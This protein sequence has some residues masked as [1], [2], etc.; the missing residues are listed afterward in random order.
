MTESPT[1]AVA[2]GL[3]DGQERTGRRRPFS[4]WVK[5]LAN[6]KNGSSSAEGV[7]DTGRLKEMA[8]IKAPRSEDRN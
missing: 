3:P 5:K 2:N 1:R 8:P 7:V 4:N 6:F